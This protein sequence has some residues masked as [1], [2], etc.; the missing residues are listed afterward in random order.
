[1]RGKKLEREI[2]VNTPFL[3][4]FSHLYALNSKNAFLIDIIFV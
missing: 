4:T 1:M 2:K 3:S